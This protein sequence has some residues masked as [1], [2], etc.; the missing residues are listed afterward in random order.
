M[1]YKIIQN[2]KVIDV[3]NNPDFIKFLPYNHIVMTDKSNA[4]GIVG[5]DGDTIYS[6]TPQ[7]SNIEIASIQETTKEEFS[8]LRDL[9]NSNSEICADKATLDHTR[10][11]KINYLSSIC[12]NKIT[13]GFS[14]ILS[15]GKSY[16]F[17][18][19]TEDQLNL[20]MIEHQINAGVETFVY[21]ATN[22]PCRLFT[23]RDMQAIIQAF[24]NHVLYHTTYFNAAKQH[25]KSLIDIEEINL[26]TYGT[27]I[28]DTITDKAVRRILK[29]GGVK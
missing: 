14:V 3:V 21:H 23:S 24:K 22:Q 12:K 5:S 1:Y 13:S 28:T 18:L 15:D 29:N 8:R 7:R 17:K 9:L 16:D 25:I 26:F 6:F 10:Q 27:D 20:M 19:T 4:Q 2:N 11:S